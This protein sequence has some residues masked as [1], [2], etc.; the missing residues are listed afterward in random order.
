MTTEEEILWVLVIEACHFV[1]AVFCLL[2]PSDLCQPGQKHFIPAEI[3]TW[4]S[5]Y[6]VQNIFEGLSYFN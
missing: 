1:P 3:V 2:S 6:F 5:L 4:L